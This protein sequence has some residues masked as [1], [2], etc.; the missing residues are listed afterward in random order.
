MYKPFAIAPVDTLVPTCKQGRA[1]SATTNLT[2]M[3]CTPYCAKRRRFHLMMVCTTKSL[4]PK[5]HQR[6]P[7][8]SISSLQPA[9]RSCVAPRAPHLVSPHLSRRRPAAQPRAARPPA[10]CAVAP[11]HVC[12][13]VAPSP[14]RRAVLALSR[15]RARESR[16]AGQC[17]DPTSRPLPHAAQARVARP[18]CLA[19]AV[20]AAEWTARGHARKKQA[21][22][23]LWGGR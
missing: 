4:T 11:L 14:R 5:L 17:L 13:R 16:T 6:R 7:L 2:H 18:C 8:R 19:G 15:E 9:C 3:G 1:I 21:L 10:D 12:A 22:G 20:P 23:V